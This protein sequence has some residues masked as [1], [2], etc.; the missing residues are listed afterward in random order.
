L[1]NNP[2]IK[3]TNKQKS[4]KK[5]NA[6]IHSALKSKYKHFSTTKMASSMIDNKGTAEGKQEPPKPYPFFYYKEF[7][8]AQDPDPTQT[9]NTSKGHS[10]PWKMHMILNDPQFEHIVAWVPHGR[11]WR[12][13]RPREFESK[14]IPAYFEHSKFSSFIRQV[15]LGLNLAFEWNGLQ[16]IF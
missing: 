15:R 6:L 10:F 4:N 12:I 16:R 7:S 3:R 8:R 11:S 14:V 2:L 1:I 13:L 9:L 5:A